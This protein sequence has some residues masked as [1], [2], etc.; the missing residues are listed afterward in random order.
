M[1]HL[2]TE[3]IQQAI[4]GNEDAFAYLVELY[5]R[6]VYNLCYR[7]L[8]NAQEAEDAAQEAFWRAYQAL[9]RYDPQRPFITWLLSIAAHYCI[10]QQRK[11][12]IPLLDLDLLPEEDIPDGAPD[13]ARV[14]AE[15]D[16][17]EQIHQ[18][19]KKLSSLDRAAIIL[20]YWYDFSEEEI[21]RTLSL[22]VSAVKSRLFRARREL[23]ER[24]QIEMEKPLV[25]RRANETTSTV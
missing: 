19:L 22:T 4:Q 13:P 7:M 24:Y 18:L 1:S 17:Q 23:A 11:R 20:R 15:R 5:Q 6:P 9:R 25:G 21:A 8:G 12:R 3:W 10:D 16:S 2:E 14:I